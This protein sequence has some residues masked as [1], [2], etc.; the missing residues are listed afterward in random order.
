[1]AQLI[2]GRALAAVIR[3][4][5][6]PRLQ[7]LPRRP[8][9]AVIL[10][11]HDHA[12]EL[13][14]RMKQQAAETAGIRFALQRFD[15]TVLEPSVLE[16]I[17]QWNND[18]Q[19]DAI[20][21]QLPLPHSLHE[22]NVVSSI[23]PNKD[24]DGFHPVN[25]GRYVSGE[26]TDPPALVEGILRLLRVPEIPLAGLT[27]TLIARSSVFTQCLEHAL[28]NEGMQTQT[29]P[30]DGNH[31]AATIAADAVIVAAGMSK[32]VVGDDLKPGCIVVDVGIN[33]LADGK[34]T[35]DVDRATV[36][37]VASWITPVPGGVGPMTIAMLLENVVR[38]AERNQV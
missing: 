21:V 38:L 10:I 5:L 3:S 23:D 26:R 14:V 34:T 32:L 22:Q 30:P 24:V 17:K 19:T 28:K 20:L 27:C 2:D 18:P 4:Q 37:R 1:M 8:G 29:V 33:R 35:G 7:R 12:S 16:I 31:R 13:Y 36:D 9:L 6:P 11:G 25:I 15:T